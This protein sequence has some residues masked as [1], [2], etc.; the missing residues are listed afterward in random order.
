MP[1]QSCNCPGPKKAKKCP[2]SP[3]QKAANRSRPAG[4]ALGFRSRPATAA[5]AAAS[6]MMGADSYQP[7]DMNAGALGG[8]HLHLQNQ[9]DGAAIS[10]TSYLGAQVATPAYAGGCGTPACGA[11]PATVPSIAPINNCCSAIGP[12]LPYP[13][14]PNVGMLQACLN[15]RTN[16][17]F[18][19]TA[20]F[21]APVWSPAF[22]QVCFRP[23]CASF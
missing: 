18:C 11:V 23:A 4:A 16:D 19:C 2:C 14:D 13:C 22:I 9:Y 7:A 8:D 21:Q 1:S 15:N 20:P 5:S 6:M 10:A 17:P 12:M 3:S